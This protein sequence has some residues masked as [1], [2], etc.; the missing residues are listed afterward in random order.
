MFKMKPNDGK[1]EGKTG[2]ERPEDVNT[3][4]EGEDAKE[5]RRNERRS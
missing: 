1:K 4:A 3:K 5:E 2:R